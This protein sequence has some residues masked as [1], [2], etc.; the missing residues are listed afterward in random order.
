MGNGE[1]CGESVVEGGPGRERTVFDELSA[2][3][4]AG[5]EEAGGEEVSV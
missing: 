4:G 3:G 1:E 5:E 2:K